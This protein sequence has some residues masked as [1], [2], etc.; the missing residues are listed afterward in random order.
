[1]HFLKTFST[2][3]PM[4]LLLQFMSQV[5]ILMYAGLYTCAVKYSA[6]FF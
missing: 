2:Y 1:M 6:T 3:M 4:S 5:N